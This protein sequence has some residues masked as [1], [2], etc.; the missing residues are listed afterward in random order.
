MGTAVTMDFELI[1][2]CKYFIDF[3][4]FFGLSITSFFSLF[5]D[6]VNCVKAARYACGRNYKSVLQSKGD[7]NS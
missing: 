1:G 5:Y 2:R 4:I 6:V 7:V 3:A